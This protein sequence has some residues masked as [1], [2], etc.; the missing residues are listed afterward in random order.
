MD[1]QDQPQTTSQ[2]PVDQ[3]SQ[4]IQFVDDL[5][6]QKFTGHEEEVTPEVR[7]ELRMDL[8]T[9]LDEFIMSKMIAEFSEEDLATFE[10][11]MKEGKT[12]EELQQFASSRIPDFTDFATDV[13]LEF[14]DVYLN[15]E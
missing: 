7:D 9:S 15:K 2:T 10:N 12:R 6:N 3:T 8:M 13:F 1:P 5:I 14:R 4:V 11:M